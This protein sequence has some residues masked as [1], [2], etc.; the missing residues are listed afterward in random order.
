MSRLRRPRTWSFAPLMAGLLAVIIP[1]TPVGAHVSDRVGHL[2][3]EHLKAKTD[4]RYV[5]PLF[6][7][8]SRTGTL[9]RERGV[10]SSDRVEDPG[11]YIVR[12]TRNVRKCVYVATLGDASSGFPDP[13]EISVSNSD[14]GTTTGVW[15]KTFNSS[16]AETNKAFHLAAIC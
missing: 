6:A 8:V 2:W 10:D 3:N 11:F 4:D 14:D 5:R 9:R 13:G 16:G 7:L 15:V 12:F 1:L